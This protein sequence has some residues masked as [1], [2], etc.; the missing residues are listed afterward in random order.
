MK[1]ATR[2]YPTKCAACGGSGHMPR[3]ITGLLGPQVRPPADCPACHGTGSIRVVEVV[4][5]EDVEPVRRAPTEPAERRAPEHTALRWLQFSDAEL[6][7]L[8]GAII[9]AREEIARFRP[10]TDVSL[11]ELRKLYAEIVRARQG[12]DFRPSVVEEAE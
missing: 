3:S 11:S 6:A 5:M 1:N 2:I 10:V 8:Q 12:S 4:P 9:Y 7:Q